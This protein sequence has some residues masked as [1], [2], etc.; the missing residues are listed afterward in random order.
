MKLIDLTHS[1]SRQQTPESA[2]RDFPPVVVRSADLVEKVPLDRLVTMATVV[3][4]R[5]RADRD[6]IGKQDMTSTGVADIGGCILRTDWCDNYLSGMR[7]DAPVLEMDAATYLLQ[8]GVRTIAADFPLTGGVADLLMHNGC[9]L[10]YC[11]SNVG[12]ITRSIVRLAALP[13]KFED[14]FAADARVIAIEQ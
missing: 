14:T 10:I 8:G 3:D 1:M 12:E 13:L 2:G 5:E 9:V 11:V 4:V 7:E 6:A